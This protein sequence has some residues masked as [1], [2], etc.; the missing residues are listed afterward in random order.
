MERRIDRNEMTF[1]SSCRLFLSVFYRSFFGSSVEYDSSVC[2]QFLVH[3]FTKEFVS[4]KTQ[5]S[6]LTGGE[7]LFLRKEFVANI[8]NIM[9]CTYFMFVYKSKIRI[10]ISSNKDDR[11]QQRVLVRHPDSIRS[12]VN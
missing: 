9:F 2:I 4:F 12:M 1:L 3:Q 7:T 10:R 8:L 5:R 6:K 11:V